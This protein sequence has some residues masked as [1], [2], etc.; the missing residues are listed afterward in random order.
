[1]TVR[2]KELNGIGTPLKVLTSEECKNKSVRVAKKSLKATVGNSGLND[3]EL[4]T[5][6]KEV[7]ALMNSR[8]LGYEGTDP[9][10]EPVLTPSHFLI[11][12][13]GGQLAPR[14]TDQIAFNPRRRWR[15]VQS[16]VKTFWK[17]WR[18]EF[19]ATLNTRKKS[20]EA[21]ENLR[22]GDVVLVVDQNAP[23]GKW[24]L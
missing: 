6:L 14:V 19:L 18:E 24:H 10:D 12:K 9:R 22:V 2:T 11:G 8:P 16:L 1:M 7:E 3:D 4:Q 15:L 17:R 5:A 20:G 23:R 13:L 21:K